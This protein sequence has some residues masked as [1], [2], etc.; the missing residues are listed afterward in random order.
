MQKVDRIPI[1]DAVKLITPVIP[2]PIPQAIPI[3]QKDQSHPIPPELTSNMNLPIESIQTHQKLIKKIIKPQNPP[4]PTPLH[5]KYT[6]FTRL[7]PLET[8]KKPK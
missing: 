5:D 3:P 7:F 6:F 2:E 8:N 4:E 1:K